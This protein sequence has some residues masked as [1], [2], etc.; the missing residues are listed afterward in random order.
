MFRLINYINKTTNL[1]RHD[2]KQVCRLLKIRAFLKCALTMLLYNVKRLMKYIIRFNTSRTLK[3]GLYTETMLPR[4]PKTAFNRKDQNALYTR[5][6][7]NVLRIV[8][9]LNPVVLFM[10]RYRSF[11]T[12]PNNH[13]KDERVSILLME[14]STGSP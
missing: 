13:R 1:A 7:F 5:Y 3:D 14:S 8:L 9:S 12:L 11:K 4:F 10:T 2:F 6:V